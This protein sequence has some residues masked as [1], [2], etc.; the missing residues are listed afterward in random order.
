MANQEEIISFLIEKI[1]QKAEK[2][3]TTLTDEVNESFNFTG[4]GLFDSM[5]F[6]HLIVEVEE[7]FGVE[8]DFSDQEPKVFTTVG[9]FARCIK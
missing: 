2:F 1:Y 5:D 4:S 3:E 8:V 6:M 9:G 7:K